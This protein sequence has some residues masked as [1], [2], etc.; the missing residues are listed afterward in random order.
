MQVY[1]ASA[2]KDLGFLLGRAG[3]L[4][5]IAAHSHHSSHPFTP[6]IGRNAYPSKITHSYIIRYLAII[7][8]TSQH[9]RLVPY[10]K[11]VILQGDHYRVQNDLMLVAPTLVLHHIQ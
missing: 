3:G 7:S 6:Y 9:D 11:Y 8:S 10:L 4:T 2:Q 5:V 1:N